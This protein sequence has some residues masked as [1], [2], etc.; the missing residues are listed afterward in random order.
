M[1]GNTPFSYL[2]EMLHLHNHWATDFI[3]SL[4]FKLKFLNRLQMMK[5]PVPS[6]NRLI[7]QATCYYISEVSIWL[8]DEESDNNGMIL[9]TM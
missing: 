9:C 2:Y 6:T 4:T 3:S 7:K 5:N 8:H 1:L